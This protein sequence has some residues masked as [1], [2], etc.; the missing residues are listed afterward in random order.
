M[1]SKKPKPPTRVVCYA[2]SSKKGL[3]VEAQ[4]ERMRSYA[5]T[6]DLQIVAIIRKTLSSNHS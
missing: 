2:R 5:K 6:Y 3:G 4:A 1:S